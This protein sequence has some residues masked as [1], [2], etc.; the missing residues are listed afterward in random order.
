MINV[1]KYRFETIVSEEIMPNYITEK[2]YTRTVEI[3]FLKKQKELYHYQI[4][5][6][7]FDFSDQDTA[8]GFFLKKISY[9]FD[10]LDL[11]ADEENN[12]VKINNISS[13]RL[14]WQG[15]K[16]KL[17]ET[18]KGDVVENYFR[19]VSSVFGNEESLIAFLHNY[20]MFGLYFNGQLGQYPDDG[21]KI[22]VITEGK[23]EH[24]HKENL[25]AE[26]N[27]IKWKFSADENKNHLEG[28]SIYEKGILKENYVLSRENKCEIKYSLLWVG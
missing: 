7:K 28:T 1:N 19:S 10:E 26:Q 14:R 20:N 22:R 23:I 18:N 5:C 21:K 13:L 24:L 3:F 6:T 17:L 9:L 4:L 25:S 8:T 16:V 27:E 15:L 12:I 11:Y 2:K